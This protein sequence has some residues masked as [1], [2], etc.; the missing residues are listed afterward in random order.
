MKKSSIKNDIPF[1]DDNIGDYLY[2]NIIKDV[3]DMKSLI[4]KDVMNNNHHEVQNN[5]K[6]LS[7][8]NDFIKFW[9]NY[10]AQ[11]MSR[12]QENGFKNSHDQDVKYS[13]IKP[14]M[15]GKYDFKSVLLY[16]DGM[17]KM[18]DDKNE[19]YTQGDL[20]SFFKFT[21]EKAFR[22]EKTEVNDLIST[23][24]S[25]ID[26]AVP[27]DDSEFD[28]NIIKDYDLFPESD[29]TDLYKSIEGVMNF[30][31]INKMK[32]LFEIKKRINNKLLI[33][34]AV[35]SIFDY[36]I[37]SLSFYALRI[38][39]VS[40][41][42]NS[43]IND[44]EDDGEVVEESALSIFDN[45]IL[46]LNISRNEDNE[47]YNYNNITI[48]SS[49][50]GTTYRN[51]DSSSFFKEFEK[52]LDCNNISVEKDKP[53]IVDKIHEMFKDIYSDSKMYKYLTD[54]KAFCTYEVMDNVDEIYLNLKYIFNNMK[55]GLE[56]E[57][58]KIIFFNT[59]IHNEYDGKETISE[60][61]KSSERIYYFSKYFF[62][63]IRQLINAVNNLWNQAMNC[64][65]IKN[66][67]GYIGYKKKLAE[68]ADFLNKFYDEFTAVIH[69]LMSDIEK[70]MC[71]INMK[72]RK[73]ALAQS[74]IDF[75]EKEFDRKLKNKYGISDDEE[76]KDEYEIEDMLENINTYSSF[77][78]MMIYREYFK[79]I[80]EIKELGYFA[81]E[82]F[83][84]TL[85]GWWEK[86]RK[87]FMDTIW[88]PLS[89]FFTGNGFEKAKKWAQDNRDALRGANWKNDTVIENVH[90]YK[91]TINLKSLQDIAKNLQL[92]AENIKDDV[93]FDNYLEGLINRYTKVADSALPTDLYNQMKS[94]KTAVQN[95]LPYYLFYDW[96]RL[97]SNF[98]EQQNTSSPF[99]KTTLAGSQ[100]QSLDWIKENCKKSVKG[101]NIKTLVHEYIEN[102]TD[103]SIDG[104]Y[105]I[106]QQLKNDIS[107]KFDSFKNS[108]KVAGDDKK[109]SAGNITGEKLGKL[110]EHVMYEANSIFLFEDENSSDSTDAPKAEENLVKD[111]TTANKIKTAFT[112]ILTCLFQP[113]FTF[114]AT[115]YVNMSKFLQEAYK[116]R[117]SESST[118]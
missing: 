104:C 85:K 97:S 99:G 66:P 51:P 89:N 75:D 64:Q 1:A 100:S 57:S 69:N 33:G 41:F 45:D 7:K 114:S 76:I 80:P 4:V 18:T 116:K 26:L 48:F 95:K 12:I 46:K 19:K 110:G 98:V 54:E 49:M 59:L 117:D 68:C 2:N 43:Y 53:V 115:Y 55:L 79:N 82:S 27:E 47:Y 94:D 24:L 87:W 84:D 3:N 81:E 62:C 67:I 10:G 92:S 112:N 111:T 16:A 71:D 52:F 83:G 65:H 108:I 25:N 14:F 44:N 9:Y 38:Y 39:V 88:T 21:I 74:S 29:Y 22:T 8:I 34:F 11:T 90:I 102:F 28:P 36:I 15:Y 5:I 58:N 32:N 23:T 96:D 91:K 56:V 107:S 77:E 31:T 37:Y 63:R 30:I 6:F 35:K 42:L 72:K 86:I 70:K 118:S 17:S 103:T 50:D 60:L 20:Q 106:L 73:D 78:N 93:A 40:K 105:K 61:R 13:T 109:D 101:E 113:L